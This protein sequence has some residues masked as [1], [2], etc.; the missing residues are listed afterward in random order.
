MHLKEW[1]VAQVDSGQYEGLSWEDEG[2]TMF[3]IP[4]K[5]AAKK[6]YKQTE[7]AALFKVNISLSISYIVL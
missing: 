1:L 5:H 2:K 7:D 6:D 4:W 3:R